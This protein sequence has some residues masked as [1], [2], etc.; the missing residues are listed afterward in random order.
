M[1]QLLER[2][3]DHVFRHGRAV[4]QR[5]VEQRYR[6]RLC[7]ILD[8]RQARIEHQGRRQAIRFL[9]ASSLPVAGNALREIPVFSL[10][11]LS[12]QHQAPL[13]LG[14]LQAHQLFRFRQRPFGNALIEPGPDRVAGLRPWCTARHRGASG[15]GHKAGQQLA[16]LD[17]GGVVLAH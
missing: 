2:G 16:A 5:F 3:K 15:G 1:R 7:G 17:Q 8:P 13:R 14:K 12:A 4:R 6:I 9:N 10:D 11:R